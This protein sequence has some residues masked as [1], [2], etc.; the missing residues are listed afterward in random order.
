ML[1]ISLKRDQYFE[2]SG[3]IC[4]ERV[5]GKIVIIVRVNFRLQNFLFSYGQLQCPW[6]CMLYFIQMNSNQTMHMT[7]WILCPILHQTY[8]S[9]NQELQWALYYILTISTSVLFGIRFKLM[10]HYGSITWQHINM[11]SN[12]A[13]WHS[14]KPHSNWVTLPESY[15]S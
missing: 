10:M 7:S 2:W 1:Q 4:C 5:G 9:L 13:Q 15:P 12:L 3:F 11:I 8:S 14:N 6:W